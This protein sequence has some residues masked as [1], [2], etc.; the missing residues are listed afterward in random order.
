[1]SG[2]YALEQTFIIPLQAMVAPQKAPIR[3]LEKIAG[4]PLAAEAA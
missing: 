1:L 3:V 4:M 2:Q